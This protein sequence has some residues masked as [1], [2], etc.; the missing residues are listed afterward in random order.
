MKFKDKFHEDAYF[1]I[2]DL[3]TNRDVY[4]MTFAYLISLDTVCRHHFTDLYDFD[5]CCL[6]TDPLDHA[7]QTGTS[8]KTTALAYNL[9]TDSTLW[10]EDNPSCCSVS[11][12]MCSV[13]APYY[14]EAIKIRYPRYFQGS[15]C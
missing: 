4:H 8:R 7:W 12:I 10:C 15:D 2:L 14:F 1:A 5:E 13:Y 6:K 11:D 3:M 9:Y